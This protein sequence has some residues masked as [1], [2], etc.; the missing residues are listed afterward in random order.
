M[1]FGTANGIKGT[2]LKNRCDH[3]LIRE[4]IDH[5]LFGFFSERSFF[6]VSDK[7]CA[8]VAGS[9]IAKLPLSIEG[10]DVKPEV[11]QD[12][13]VVDYGGIIGNFYRLIMPGVI[14]AVGRIFCATTGKP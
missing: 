14:T 8:A 7:N 1:D 13:L 2:G 3:L 11:I 9:F 10:I 4:F 12:S 5:S 6:C